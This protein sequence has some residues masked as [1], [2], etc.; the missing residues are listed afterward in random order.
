M[1]ELPPPPP[2]IEI[3]PSKPIYNDYGEPVFIV[4]E[5]ELLRPLFPKKELEELTQEYVNIL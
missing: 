5:I 1:E 3:D 2:E 4:L